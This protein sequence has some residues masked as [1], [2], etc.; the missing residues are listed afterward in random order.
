MTQ[1]LPVTGTPTSRVRRASTRGRPGWS[2]LVLVVAA[3]V[4][5]PVVAVLVVSRGTFATVPVGLWDMVVTTCAL[6]LGVGIGTF[7]L[8]VGLAWLVTGYDFPLRN[9][10]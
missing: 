5:A 7:V 8:G 9:V 2:A 4:A 10:M 3:L 6:M 1:T